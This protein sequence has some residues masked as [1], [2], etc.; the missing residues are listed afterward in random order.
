MLDASSVTHC[1][2]EPQDIPSSLIHQLPSPSARDFDERLPVAWADFV[3]AARATI[4]ERDHSPSVPKVFYHNW[5]NQ[6][7]LAG[8]HRRPGYSRLR[9][10]VLGRRYRA[11]RPLSPLLGS[12]KSLRE[13]PCVMKLNDFHAAHLAGALAHESD[14]RVVHIVRHPGGYLDS[15]VRRHFSTLSGRDLDAERVKYRAFLDEGWR[16][17]LYPDDVLEDLDGNTLPTVMRFWSANNQAI[18]ELG[19]HSSRYFRVVYEDLAANP[20]AMAA[21]LYQH[22]GLPEDAAA[23]EHIERGKDDNVWRDL[24]GSPRET[25]RRWAGTLPQEHRDLVAQELARTAMSAW[26]TA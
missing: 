3:S 20:L 9:R 12:P 6:M 18:W 8:Y 14:L 22:V 25:A 7:G 1:R 11:E 16:A 10:R 17:G 2:S 21:K 15:A 5:V 24:S 4:G 23:M 13:A 26:W 19:E